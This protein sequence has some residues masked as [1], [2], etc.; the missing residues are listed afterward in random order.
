MV[1]IAC[2]AFTMFVC[3]F[4][5]LC[6][7]LCTIISDARGRHIAVSTQ[8]TP[9]WASIFGAV[10]IASV[11]PFEFV[12]AFAAEVLQPIAVLANTRIRN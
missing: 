8:V 3:N 10:Q 5:F 7:I 9:V 2:L 12:F 11:A 1:T 6:R 4:V